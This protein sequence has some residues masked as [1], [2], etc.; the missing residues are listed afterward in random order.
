MVKIGV[1]G[2]GASGLISAIA[3]KRTNKNAQVN[4]FEGNN[5]VAKKLITTG[6]GRCNITNRNLDIKYFH[7]NSCD[8][9]IEILDR[10]NLNDTISFF[11]S[12]N[13]PIKDDG[14]N[15]LFPA[16]FQAQSV[17]DALRFECEKQQVNIICDKKIVSLDKKDDKFVLNNEYCFDK[18]IIACGGKAAPKTGSDG[19]GYAFLTQFGHKLV[20]LKESIVPLK[21]DTE[22]LKSAKGMKAD[23]LLTLK[24][25][26]MSVNSFGEILFTDYGISGPVVLQISRFASINKNVKAYI[27]FMPDYNYN[28]L[29]NEITYRV[30]NCYENNNENLLL[31][32]I[33]K[34]IGFCI[35]KKSKIPVSGNSYEISQ[36]Q[37]KN[38]VSN[39][40]NF[41]V[42]VKGV[43]GFDNAQTTVGGIDLSEFD[44]NLQSLNCKNLYSCGEILD[45]DGDCGGFNLQ[46]A[47][48]SGYIAGESAAKIN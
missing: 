13:I 40:L 22:F 20:N 28:E 48:S 47:W 38:L 3:A 17:V 10:F 34:R 39:L 11:K 16:S 5:R 9:A 23:V 32:L 26:N 14:G 7:S 37:I 36:I 12:I 1:I 43:C 8:A 45:V 30:N 19:N 18:V 27:N 31:G 21:T 29:L 25:N 41:E 24:S 42:V 46:W 35:L 2:G 4:V 33:N 6:N 15:K 44:E